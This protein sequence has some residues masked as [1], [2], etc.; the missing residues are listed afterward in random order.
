MEFIEALSK[1]LE[2]V[3]KYAW[4]VFVVCLFIIL[5]PPTE[6]QTMGLEKIKQDYLGFWWIGLIFS[7]TIWCGS[8]FSHIVSWFS[9]AR[10]RASRKSTVIKR[11]NTL[12]PSEYKWVAYCLLHNVQTLSTTAI[13]QTANSLLNKGVVTQ[14]TGH[15]LNLPFHIRDFVW[16]YLQN[17]R[18]EF[19]P[20]EVRD[21]P[22]KVYILESFAADLK[23]LF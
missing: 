21:D 18:E 23:K 20:R 7:A 4:G 12:D 8:I 1:I 19:L 9:E 13:N 3:A 2:S 22:D 10:E 5:L 14:G 6:S 16:D 15:M 11:L 17:H